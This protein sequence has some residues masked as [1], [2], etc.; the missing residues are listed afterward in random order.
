[1]QVLRLVVTLFLVA[2]I[3][4]GDYE[5]LKIVMIQPAA[6]GNTIL[7]PG[8]VPVHATLP[9]SSLMLCNSLV[10]RRLMI[11]LVIRIHLQESSSA[12]HGQTDVQGLSSTQQ[13]GGG[14]RGAGWRPE[15]PGCMLQTWTKSRVRSS[16]IFEIHVWSGK[17]LICN[18]EETPPTTCSPAVGKSSLNAPQ[19]TSKTLKTNIKLNQILNIM[20]VSIAVPQSWTVWIWLRWAL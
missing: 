8:G 2:N 20:D 16:K 14:W 6:M 1:M 3:T 12:A 10:V 5:P 15:H 18:L 9:A 19:W 13:G 17:C 7:L 11:S 4:V